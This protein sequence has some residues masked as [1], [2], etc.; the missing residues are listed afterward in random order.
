MSENFLLARNCKTLFEKENLAK[1]KEYKISSKSLAS[2]SE[3]SLFREMW[4]G[5]EDCHF[6]VF[7]S[8][9]CPFFNSFQVSKSGIA[10]SSS[11]LQ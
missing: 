3:I 1:I 4:N 11:V 7:S 10:E 6:F 2:F 8:F 5:L 9:E